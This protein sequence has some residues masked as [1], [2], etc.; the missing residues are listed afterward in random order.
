VGA[1]FGGLNGKDGGWL[2]VEGL[3]GAEPPC[4]LACAKGF[5]GANAKEG[6][7]V[8][9]GVVWKE[10]EPAVEGLGGSIC[11]GFC[12]NVNPVLEDWL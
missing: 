3:L 2:K 5:G 4:E 9:V 11:V 6:P 10:N 12:P 8:A 1:A 7:V